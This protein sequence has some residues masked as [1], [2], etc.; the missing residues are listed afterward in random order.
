VARLDRAARRA[1]GTRVRLYPQLPVLPAYRE[2]EI[3]WLSR[4]AG[5]VAPGP[6]DDRIYVVDAVGKPR[7][8]EYP[9]LPPYA[10]AMNP[11]VAPD[12]E[13]HLDRLEVGSPAFRAA[14]MYG[15]VRRLLDIW[16]SHG[17]QP[18]QW[19]F[20]RRHPR[21]ELI[22]FVEWENA[23]AG[24]GFIETGYGMDEQGNR[25]YHCLNFDVLA[26]EFGHL[27]V[28]ALMG[29]PLRGAVTAQFLGFHESAA[30]LV[31]LVSVLHFDT[32]LDHVL[33]QSEGNLYNL[34]EL[35]R[36]G[37]LSE[38]AQIRV[39]DNGLRMS[40]LPD[41]ERPTELLC[42]PARHQLAQPL[43]G[44]LFDVLVDVYQQRLVDRGLIDEALDR[45]SGRPSGT[46]V[47]DPAVDSAFASAYRGRHEAF[48]AALEN[49][50]D[51][52]GTLLGLA[53]CRVAP[54]ALRYVDVGNALLAA[55]WD[56]TGGRYYDTIRDSLMW[57]EIGVTH[58]GGRRVRLA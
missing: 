38:T 17:G 8:Y 48:R 20:R 31:A 58:R 53:W 16:E 3:V 24:F 21:L 13:G 34:T 43:T 36:I 28:Y 37:E 44:A 54:D 1:H 22:P 33:R 18:I 4:P 2:P 39:A 23:H 15:S 27:M 14:H 40:D 52:V 19:H 50:R 29:N 56:L 41:T 55:D 25:Q 6:A 45:M 51:Y 7:P 11:P 32:V 42:Q 5:T 47:E 10:G 26:H 35:S 9:F 49:A 12:R 57:R 46:V 30:D